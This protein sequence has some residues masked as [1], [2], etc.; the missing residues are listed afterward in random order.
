METKLLPCPFCGYRAR[1]VEGND[2]PYPF[3][4]WCLNDDC[5]A[6]QGPYLTEQEVVK[7]WN[8]RMSREQLMK[9]ENVGSI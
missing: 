1:M 2:C 6:E 3:S 7:A 5:W 8:T 9:E 4:V